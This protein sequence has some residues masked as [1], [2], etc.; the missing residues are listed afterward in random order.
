LHD[1][2]S[3]QVSL[4]AHIT[5]YQTNIDVKKDTKINI[6]LSFCLTSSIIIVYNHIQPNGLSQVFSEYWR[7]IFLQ[8]QKLSCCTIHTP[9]KGYLQKWRM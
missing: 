9:F 3:D 6:I 1:T 4:V 7:A 5:N 8:L 2:P